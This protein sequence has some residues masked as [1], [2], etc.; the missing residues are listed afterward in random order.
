[1]RDS[2]L[3]YR[4]FYEAV[5]NLPADEFKRSVQ[6]IMEYGLNEIEPETDGIERTV[7]LLTKP[8]IDANNRRYENGSKGGKPKSNQNVTKEEPKPNQ[9]ETTPEPKEKD[10]VKEKDKDKDNKYN[11]SSPTSGDRLAYPYGDIIDYLNQRSGTKYRST[12]EDTRKHIRAR[13]N[14]G[15]TVEN[16]R[17]V[18]DKK[19]SEWKGGDMEKFLRPS[20]LFGTKFESYLNQAISAPKGSGFSNFNQRDYDFDELER[21]LTGG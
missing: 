7:F 19:V 4:S 5:K 9:D 17:T 6:A 11:V 3:F 8:Q 10:K 2:V 20:T 16:F 13:M 18:I 12:S 14:E 15:Y 1:M 21:K